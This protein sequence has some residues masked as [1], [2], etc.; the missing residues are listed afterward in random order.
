LEPIVVDA[1]P[2]VVSCLGTH[3]NLPK[4]LETIQV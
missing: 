4:V 2:V 3:G 1:W